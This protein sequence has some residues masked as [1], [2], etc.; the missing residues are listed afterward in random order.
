MKKGFS[1]VELLVVIAIIAIL[2]A[3]LLPALASAKQTGWQAQCINNQRQLN[4]AYA[5]FA[6]DHED[7]FPYA[8]AWRAEPTGMWAWVADSM[9]GSGVWGQTD[10]PLFW[11]PLKPYAG[12][13][14]FSCPGDK[15]T[16]IWQEKKK[17]ST[18]WVD[19]IKKRPRSYSVNIF[20]GGWS[21]WP[22]E[23][24]TQYKIYHTYDDVKDPSSIF[25][26]IE[27]PSASINA[28]NFRVP[29]T[30]RGKE[31]AFSM[32]WPG[33]YHN[34]GSVVSFVDAHVEFRRW[35]EEDTKVIPEAVQNPTTIKDLVISPD[36]RDIKWLGDRATEPYPNTHAWKKV[37]N[38][39]SRYDRPWN[40]R[41]VDGKR[42]DSWGWYWNDSWGHHPTWK[43]YIQ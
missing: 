30:M 31:S 7:R 13:K 34:N 10:R 39:I 28:G 6:A 15:S 36:N 26:F 8:S 2:A 35:L 27:M 20:V 9:S 21:G 14:I 42:Y 37:M 43:P 32:D 41:D 33:V 5:E 22:F 38:G 17:G 29:P 19:N 23:A 12:M 16:V 11:S 25:S 4:L 18:N 1:L 24:D 3:L 40:T